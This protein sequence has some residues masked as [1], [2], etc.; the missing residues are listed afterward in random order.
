MNSTH[1]YFVKKVIINSLVGNRNIEWE[2]NDDVNVLV[3][4]NGSG[5]STLIKLIKLVL[6]GPHRFSE[7][8]L[9]PVK[10][11]FASIKVELN[12]GL[13]GSL[14][15]E[16]DI[17]SQKKL[18]KILAELASDKEFLEKI[19][20]ESKNYSRLKENLDNLNEALSE[21]KSPK[22]FTDSI[23]Y[24]G[25]NFIDD[26]EKNLLESNVNIE[27]ISTF[28]MLLLSKEEF[29]EMSGKSYSQLDFLIDKEISYLTQNL[30]A[31]NKQASDEYRKHKKNKSLESILRSK[32]DR[33]NRFIK[34]I[35]KL[36]NPNK[37]DFLL[38]KETGKFVCKYNGNKIDISEFSSGEK[39]MV[40]I[41]LKVLN[42]GNKPSILLM[43]E[44]EISLHMNW[45]ENLI[46][47]IK[48]INSNCQIIIVSHSP[49]V[50]MK[51][52]LS[53]LVDIKDITV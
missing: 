26:N 2:L 48:K 49:A 41:L 20:N 44:P 13:H 42:S 29:D 8:D 51:G 31:L 27:L 36:F 43:D 46:S 40:M 16:S 19:A 15:C 10:R 47:T 37:K 30:L 9:L 38:D 45:Q 11:K 34:E 1:P 17:N 52:W 50:V 35:N 14:N 21:V 22:N 32:E 18:L 23:F 3:G 39:Q 33:Y 28:D 25:A 6:T 7:E 53:R 12:N 5:K 4:A 24:G